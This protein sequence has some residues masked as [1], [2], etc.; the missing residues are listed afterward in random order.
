[1]VA[2]A[3]G[4]GVREIKSLDRVVRDWMN[5]LSLGFYVTPA[6][7]SD[8]H[9]TSHDPVGMPRTFV[10]VTDDSPSALESGAAVDSVLATQTGANST[11]RDVVVTDG[12]M[13][14]V[15]VGGTSNPALGRV[16]TATANSVT[17]T[18]TATSPDWAE[19]D[20]LEVFANATPGAVPSG[21]VSTLV[22]LKC[23]TTRDIAAMDAADPCMQAAIAPE[24]VAMPLVTVSGAGNAKRYELSLDVTLAASDI[25]NR[26]GA[27]GTDAWLVFRVRGDRSI[28]PLLTDDAV[29]D[30]T[31]P[32]LLGGDMTAIAGALKGRGIPAAAITA[33]VFVD[34][35]ADGKYVAPFAP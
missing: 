14:D 7:N 27:T 29:D 19:I 6:G 2:D 35:D 26:A 18:V 8:T 10:R 24:N 4:D 13:I 1:V 17:V 20:T 33:P 16:V 32:T 5:M 12:P 30:T 28:F 15:V 22:P 34:F 23:W 9:T 3:N 25:V 21:D 11:A 31:L